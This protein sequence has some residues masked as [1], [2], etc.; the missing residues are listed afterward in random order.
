[1]AIPIKIKCLPEPQLQLSNGRLDFDPRRALST[2]R[3]VDHRGLRTI[4][5]GLI[6]L[7]DDVSAARDWIGALD[8]FKPARERNARRFRDWHPN[9]LL[10]R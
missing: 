10:A 5:V 4:R 8:A 6:G 3:P 2:N 7:G 1:M 9:P